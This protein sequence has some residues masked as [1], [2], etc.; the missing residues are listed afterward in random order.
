[1]RLYVLRIS[2]VSVVVSVMIVSNALTLY[3]VRI[4]PGLRV[5]A[6]ALTTSMLVSNLCLA[7]VTANS[8]VHNILGM[9]PCSLTW[10]KAA[11]RPVERF[12][13]YSSMVHVGFIAVDRYIAVK[14]ALQ[15]E[16][17]VT[18]HFCCDDLERRS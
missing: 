13:I 10:Y 15:Y 2:V 3:A 6:Y 16:N 9:T 8:V 11:V 1:M 17:R 5:K 18:R 7:I 4:T 14:H 12:V